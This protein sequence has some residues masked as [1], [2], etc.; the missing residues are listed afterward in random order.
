MIVHT[1][2]LKW[3]QDNIIIS[4]FHSAAKYESI[5]SLRFLLAGRW[6]EIGVEDERGTT[7]LH[8]ASGHGRSEAA[9]LLVK[10]GAR[11]DKQTKAGQTAIHLASLRGRDEIIK[12]LLLKK[13]RV[14]VQ[15]KEGLTPLIRASR[16]GHLSTVEM[17]LKEGADFGIRAPRRKTAFHYAAE[18]GR[19]PVIKLLLDHPLAMRR[20]L[21]S[22]A[23][24]IKSSLDLAAQNGHHE[25]VCMLLKQAKTAEDQRLHCHDAIRIAAVNAR[26][27]AVEALF[28]YQT[29]LQGE[30][31]SR[32]GLLCVAARG[33][34]ESIVRLLLDLGTPVD[35]RDGRQ[36]TALHHMASIPYPTRYDLPMVDLLVAK[37]ADLEAEIEGL[38][39]LLIA[40]QA[41]YA[42]TKLPR[43]LAMASHLLQKGASVRARDPNGNTALHIA[44]RHESIHGRL[45]CRIGGFI[46]TALLYHGADPNS[47]NYAGETPLH[48]MARPLPQLITLFLDHGFDKEA[49]DNDGRTILHIAAQRGW[50][51]VIE[52]M[53]DRGCSVHAKDS[54]GLTLLHL[55]V[56]ATTMYN[57]EVLDL[58]L[59]AGADINCQD[60]T[61]RTALHYAAELEWQVN[62][63]RTYKLLS[64]HGADVYVKDSEG[65]QPGY[66]LKRANEK[67]KLKKSLPRR[68][69]RQ[70]K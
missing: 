62:R 16:N 15:D 21:K 31:I 41:W 52:L 32:P 20:D 53:L 70:L 51:Y 64:E 45:Y 3:G 18:Y 56:I 61:G 54:N 11:V 48:I 7:A 4:V 42:N 63:Q 60:G 39:P 1:T 12:F 49:A 33:R 47:A 66:L 14:N 27:N 65:N 58:L 35:Q 55:A 6:V 29:C 38:T 24:D 57:I 59:D 68:G 44:A 46:I 50:Q 69:V 2:R 17:L 67:A 43:P 40:L 5:P 8:F 34:T 37:G 28:K 10:R 36:K 22:R 9:R 13:A 23:D 30:E 25:V 19:L 26:V